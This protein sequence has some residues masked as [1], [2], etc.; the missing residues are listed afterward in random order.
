MTGRPP[1]TSLLA[2]ATILVATVPVTPQNRT[3]VIPRVAITHINVVDVTD[4]RILPD[5]TVTIRGGTIGS[6]TSSSA[7]SSGAASGGADGATITSVTPNGAPPKNAQVVDGQGRFLVP[8][9]W[10][11]HAHM[12][13]TGASWLQL[14]V[15][16]GVTGIRDM[17]SDVDL[18]LKLREATASGLLLGP[19]I[20]AAGPILDNAPG[21]WPFRQRVTTTDEGRAAVQRLK[22]RGVDLIKVHDNT[23]RDVFFAIADEARRQQLPLAGH[24]ARAVSV[25]EAVEAGQRDIEH[26]AG[27]RLW[28]PCSGRGPYSA[29][30]CRPFFEMLA[31]RGIWQTPTLAAWSEIG[32]IG[33]P[34]SLVTA[35]QL[36]Y[37]GKG[38]RAMWAENQKLFATPVVVR[39][40]RARALT[41][42]TV[43]RDLA[44]AGVGILAGCDTMIAG[45]CVHDELAAM[46]RGGMTPLAAL[47]T[48][49]IN[50]ARYL[51]LSQTLGRVAPG[52]RADLVLLDANPLA[53]IANVR[54]V[55]AVVA[56]GR[57]LDRKALDELLAQV[58]AAA[59]Q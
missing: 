6:A 24:L 20:V 21:D 16:N 2:V 51:G 52:Q 1:V 38:L 43:T 9:L 8:G 3:P 37:A 17:G 53:D 5:C 40:L 46:V 57:F 30:K 58:R 55:R 13:A 54:R 44:A 10:D 18:I 56:A 41:G 7:T 25:Q 49:T 19:R 22:Q 48:A 39:L 11:M 45:F 47:Q 34:A 36:A 29:E 12:E 31:R 27:L 23:P 32:T 4:G 28:E 59:R 15:A 50:P 35:D 42:A 33:T 14:N 26:L